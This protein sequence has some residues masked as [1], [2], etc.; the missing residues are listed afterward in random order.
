MLWLFGQIWLWLLLSFALGAGLTA[1]VLTQTRGR[2]RDREQAGEPAGEAPA[3]APPPVNPPL[4]AEET[5]QLPTAA[6][7]APEPGPGPEP[8]PGP[9]EAGPPDLGH[10]EGTLPTRREWH[11]R[12]EWPDEQDVA[13]SEDWRPRHSG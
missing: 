13:E 4:A 8:E 1:L 6:T 12:N 2:T 3:P 7:R 11:Q 5:Q 9:D 10:R